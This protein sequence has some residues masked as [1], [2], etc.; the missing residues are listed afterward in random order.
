MYPHFNKE[1]RNTIL[2]FLK[3]FFNDP[4]DLVVPYNPVIPNYHKEELDALFNGKDY[5]ENYKILSKRVRDLGENIPPLFNAYM[6]LSP[7][8]RTFGTIVNEVFGNVEETAIL[9]TMKDIYNT[10]KDR[11]IG[12]YIPRIKFKKPKL[13]R[14][15]KKKK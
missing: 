9:I 1:A 6:S 3:R 10:K 4:D 2:Y 13:P 15:F 5:K 12:T 14:L 11:H 8:M 7:T